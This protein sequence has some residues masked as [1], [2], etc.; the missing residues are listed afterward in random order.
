MEVPCK[1]N[2]LLFNNLF[3]FSACLILFSS[4]QLVWYSFLY[5]L[6]FDILFFIS[7]CMIF[8]S[9]SLLVWYSFLPDCQGLRGRENSE[10]YQTSKSREARRNRYFDAL[11]WPDAKLAKENKRGETKII[12]LL[13]V[14]QNQSWE[15][16][17]KTKRFT[18]DSFLAL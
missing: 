7:A 10:Q 15:R 2:R 4:S 17:T 9:S 16:R 13:E 18:E 11:R 14:P 8:F 3:F 12:Q 6:L 1:Y 5:F